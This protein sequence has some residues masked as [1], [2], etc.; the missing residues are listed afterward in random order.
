MWLTFQYRPFTSIR[1]QFAMPGSRS[2]K[3][4][5]DPDVTTKA[6]TRAKLYSVW[7]TTLWPLAY[8]RFQKKNQAWALVSIVSFMGSFGGNLRA[9]KRGN[10]VPQPSWTCSQTMQRPGWD[11]LGFFSQRSLYVSVLCSRCR[12][13]PRAPRPV[14]ATFFGPMMLA[15]AAMVFIQQTR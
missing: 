5:P 2:P 12:A 7:D 13:Q 9:S 4:I 10:K 1:D 6:K 11:R 14:R 8:N 3:S 15:G